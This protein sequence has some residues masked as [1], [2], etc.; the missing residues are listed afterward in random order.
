M[1]TLQPPRNLPHKLGLRVAVVGAGVSGIGMAI[2]L[3]EAGL[4]YTLFEKASAP[5]GTWRDNRYPGLTC[6]V[7]ALVYTYSFDRQ[8]HWPRLLAN[9]REIQRYHQEV[10]DRRGLAAQTRFDSEVVDARWIGDHWKLTTASGEAFDFEVVVFACGFLHHPRVPAIAGLDDFAGACFHS[11]RWDDA[12]S[13]EGRRVGVVGTGSSGV[14]IA[15]ALAGTAA[16]LS[17]FQRTAQWVFP[18]PNFRMPRWVGAALQRRPEQLQRIIEWLERFGDRF[19][20]TASI[21]SGLQRRIFGWICRRHLATVRDPVLRRRLTP[22]DEPL[23]KRPVVST[24]FYRAMQRDDV[25]LVGS[26]IERVVP[27]GVVTRDGRTHA[28]D[29]LVLATGF[30]AHAFM[31]PTRVLGE[32]GCS[33]DQVWKEGPWAYNTMTIPGFPNLFLMLGP[34]SPLLSVSIHSSV[35]RQADYILR[36]LGRLAE[37]DAVAVVP[38]EDASERWLSEIREGM[39]GTVWSS[40]CRSWYLGRGNVPVLWPFDRARWY[41]KLAEP[42]RGDFEVRRRTTA[43]EARET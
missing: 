16:H 24:R 17:V 38:T 30:D 7:P 1:T 33:I 28:L 23:C 14:Q 15:T 18:I 10:F 8:A 37:P 22:V 11:A 29:V 6:D 42:T 12:V 5:G 39:A 36:A 20:G 19:I 41:D 31:R 26:E 4:P 35:E 34:H 43:D 13:V 3:A 40:G 21:R 2:K 9:G 27:E 25:E 32:D